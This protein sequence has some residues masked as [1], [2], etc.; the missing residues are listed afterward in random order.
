MICRKCKHADATTSFAGKPVCDD[1]RDILERTNPA[2]LV[3]F[4]AETQNG[5]RPNG[6]LTVEQAADLLAVSSRTVYRMI[7]AGELPATRIG[8][9]VRI[10]QAA[11]E[12]FLAHQS[13]QPG[14]LFGS[15]P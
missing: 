13:R 1:C 2:K 7:E 14:S 11:I 12:R 5:N 9:T 10:Q 15:L 4:L 3:A 6:L 8:K